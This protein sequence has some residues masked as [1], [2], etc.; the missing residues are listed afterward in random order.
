MIPLKD[1]NPTVHKPVLTVL[2]IAINVFIY[3]FVQPHG[4]A[5]VASSQIK[6]A[7]FTYEPYETEREL[8]FKDEAERVAE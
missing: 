8:F 3:F 2:L 6:E 1:E 7:R 5:G 4:Q